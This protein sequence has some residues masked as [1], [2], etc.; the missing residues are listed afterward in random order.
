MTLNGINNIAGSNGLVPILLVF[1]AYPY[2]SK[3]DFLTST[4]IQHVINIKNTIK[5]TRSQS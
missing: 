4:I 5:N 3:F 2:I 1:G